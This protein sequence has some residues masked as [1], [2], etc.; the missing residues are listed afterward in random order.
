MKINNKYGK[1]HRED[2]AKRAIGLIIGFEKLL[3]RCVDIRPDLKQQLY[4]NLKNE[5]RDFKYSDFEED[6]DE[7]W[8][9]QY[10]YEIRRVD[11]RRGIYE[12]ADDRYAAILHELT[13]GGT[14]QRDSKGNVIRYGLYDKKGGVGLNEGATEYFARKLYLKTGRKTEYS[15]P[16]SNNIMVIEHLVELYGENTILDA[17]LNGTKNLE[18]LMLKDGKKYSDLRKLMDK[19]HT[20]IY[21]NNGKMNQRIAYKMYRKAEK[22]YKKV[23]D[24]IVEIEK[25]R[26]KNILKNALIESGTEKRNSL[27]TWF[28]NKKNNMS[29]L[30]EKSE[31]DS[32]LL[33]SP[34]IVGESEEELDN[35]LKSRKLFRNHIQVNTKEL[36]LINDNSKGNSEMKEIRET[37]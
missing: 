2:L 6:K 20:L 21:S 29:E 7:N 12:N 17:M 28:K 24:F 10:E 4:D 9:A 37:R 15:S 32:I 22:T 26:N 5:V 34:L 13:H 8:A 23:E 30:F 31:D 35:R 25:K 33:D 14:M 19:Y 16:Y 3:Y 1:E 36:N 27:F 11:L 18:S